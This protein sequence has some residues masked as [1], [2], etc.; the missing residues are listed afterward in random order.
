MKLGVRC[1]A[2]REQLGRLEGLSPCSQEHDLVLTVLCLPCSLD[3]GQSRIQLRFGSVTCSCRLSVA[4]QR[5]QLGDG[6]LHCPLS[7]EFGQ[8]K[9]SKPDYGHVVS[10]FSGNSREPL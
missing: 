10:P 9:P 7:S 6:H 5:F 1:Q 3:S 8:N 4:M 2:Q